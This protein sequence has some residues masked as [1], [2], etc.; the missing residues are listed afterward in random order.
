[1]TLLGAASV[2]L[3][4]PRWHGFSPSASAE[5]KKSKVCSVGLRLPVAGRSGLLALSGA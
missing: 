3:C 1:M 4:G 5:D 2:V